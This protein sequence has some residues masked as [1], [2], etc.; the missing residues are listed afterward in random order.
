[1]IIDLKKLPKP[2]AFRHL[3]ESGLEPRDALHTM[4]SWHVRSLHV[5]HRRCGIFATF[6]L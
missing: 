2:E 6:Y 4:L 3:L 5:A 1:M